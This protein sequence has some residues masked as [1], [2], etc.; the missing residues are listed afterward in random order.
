MIDLAAPVRTVGDVTVFAD[1]ADPTRCHYVR[2]RPRLVTDAAGNPDVKL[3]KYHLDPATR[4]STGAGLFLLNI[5]LEVPGDVLIEVR[6][7]IAA[8]V[9]HS[10]LTLTPVWPDSGT[11]QLILLDS[12]P[13]AAPA[14][15]QPATPAPPPGQP[16]GTGPAPLVATVIGGAEPDLASNAATLFA[17]TLEPPGVAIVE[18]ALRHGGLPFGAVYNLHV[19]GLRP[20]LRATVSAD[21]QASYHYYENRLHGGRLLAAADVGATVQDLVQHQAIRI[22]VDD[23]VPDADKDGIY[24]QALDQVQQYVLETLFTPTISQQ[25]AGPGTGSSAVQLVTGLLGL[26]TLTYT[27]NTI[28]SS[29]LKTLTYSLAVARA[30]EI[31]LAPQA[32]LVALLP[33]GLQ[34]DDV[35]VAVN[36]APPDQLTIDVASMIDLAAEGIDHLDVTLSYSGTDTAVTLDPASPRRTVS[37]WYSA[38]G[39]METPYRYE[40]QLAANGPKGISGRL[41]SAPATSI[42][43]LVRID[44]RELYQR[45]ELRPVLQGVPFDRFPR[46][47]LDAEAHEALDG[48]TVT[49]TVTLSAAD[50]ETVLSYRGRRDG[51]ISLRTRVRYVQADGGELTRDWQDTD[52]GPLVLGDPEPGVVDVQVLASARFGTAISRLVV[53]LRPHAAPGKVTMLTFDATTTGATWSFQPSGHDRGYDYRVTVQTAAGE[54]RPGDWHAGPA[55]PQL[56]VGEG[57]TRLRT[58]KVVFVGTTLAAAGM[59]AAR[60]RLTFDDTTANLSA[61]DSFLVQDPVAAL[62]WSYPVADPARQDYTMVI[63]WVRADGTSYDAPPQ[64]GSDLLRVVPIVAATP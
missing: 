25:P 39:G 60:V 28:D 41:T 37:L 22:T 9:G 14:S 36:P 57:F 48:W 11:C 16:S 43:D 8:A 45:A 64:A 26:F 50:A 46:V 6:D 54:V 15:A 10:G 56:V 17:C 44:P 55:D 49:D 23:L 52:P 38:A 27:L 47:I 34:A 13:A 53:E 32:E 40:A 12:G 7:K 19:A 3:I 18:Q 29:E 35:I 63:T 21:Y 4:G 51:L 59:L 42:H 24:Q 33:P 61:D 1:H 31:T 62:T 2:V 20:A 58:V 5:D 30:E